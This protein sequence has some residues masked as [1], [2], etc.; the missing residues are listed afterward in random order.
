MD[1]NVNELQKQLEG[2][3]ARHKVAGASVALFHKGKL[4]TAVAGV[5]NVNTG[6]AITTD[7]VM[8]IG[9]ITKVFNATL[10]MQLVDEGLIDLDQ[11]VLRYLPDLRLKDLE[12]LERITVK[13]LLNHTSG[14]DGAQNLVASGHD[15]D[16][17]EKVVARMGELGQ[18]FGPG[19]EYSYCNSAAVIAGYLVQR[20]TGESWYAVMRDRI[21]RP[22]E[23]RHAVTLPEEALLYRASVGHFL[24]ANLKRLVRTSSAFLPLSFAPAGVATMMSA[25]DLIAFARAH[26]AKGMGA[27]GVRILTD[28]SA[29]AMQQVTVNNKEKGYVNHD[30]GIGWMIQGTVLHHGGGAPGAG[31][32]LYVHQQQEWAAA[33]LTNAAHGMSLM[34][35]LM[36]PW[37][38]EVANDKPLATPDLQ[39]PSQPVQIDSRKYVGVYED[40]T[41]RYR[42]SDTQDGLVLTR[43]AKSRWYAIISLE[44][45]S[46]ARLIPLGDEKFVLAAEGNGPFDGPSMVTFR[47]PDSNGQ[48]RHLGRWSLYLRVQ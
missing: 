11:P 5:T 31:A 43:Q 2:S 16:T 30:V 4:I 42:V 24:D 38:D 3:L 45:T 18:L 34:R 10:V 1:I 19:T 14:I 9:S 6:V 36:E 33:I 27:N 13:M 23:M 28:R 7:T 48:M 26:M 12:A 29:N 17:I 15:E 37:V 20:L 41:L 46:P 22:L 25:T 8:H 44:E 39:L 32:M 47:N 21:F 40:S 35:E